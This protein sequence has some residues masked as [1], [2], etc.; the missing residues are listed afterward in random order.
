VY[1]Q[2]NDL[3][4]NMISMIVVELDL[5]RDLPR[6]IRVKNNIMVHPQN[7]CVVADI[8]QVSVH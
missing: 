6:S 3:H 8:S 5:N 1:I 7:E 2:V 4:Y